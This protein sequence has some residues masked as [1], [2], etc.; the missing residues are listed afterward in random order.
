MGFLEDDSLQEESDSTESEA[1][2]GRSMAALIGKL[3]PFS[4]KEET[5]GDF[6]SRF[7]EFCDLNSRFLQGEDM[8]PITRVR[9]KKLL[10]LNHLPIEVRST[11]SRLAQPDEPKNKTLDALK[12]MLQNHYNPPTLALNAVRKFQKLAQAPTETVTDFILKLKSAAKDCNFGADLDRNL[13]TQL[14]LGLKSDRTVDQISQKG[15]HD[16]V[17]NSFDD[18]CAQALQQETLEAQ[19]LER[20]NDREAL[21]QVNK[22]ARGRFKKQLQQPP[23]NTGNNNQ[24]NFRGNSR[25]FFGNNQRGEFSRRRGRGMNNNTGANNNT[26][27]IPQNNTGFNRDVSNPNRGNHRGGFTRNQGPNCWRCGR[28]GCNP[29]RCWAKNSQC[30]ECGQYGHAK[31]YH[32]MPVNAMHNNQNHNDSNNSYGGYS[33]NY[34]GA[35]AEKQEAAKFVSQFDHNAVT[36]NKLVS[37]YEDEL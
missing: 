8:D 25:G 37:N 35:N 6:A 7:E 16:A 23:N 4:P 30:Y 2:P 24:S 28:P 22:M 31:Y 34:Q 13:H 26:S 5:F 20:K 33:S 14:C 36:I 21:A 12:Q 32:R 10:F 9:K 17:N 3:E 15:V 11:L 19:R 1:G 18:A 29:D 27:N